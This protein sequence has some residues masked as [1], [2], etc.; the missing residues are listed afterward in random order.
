MVISRVK[1]LLNNFGIKAIFFVIPGLIDLPSHD[2][3]HS[4]N[5]YIFNGKIE[6]AYPLRL[7]TWNELNELKNDGHEIGCHGMTHKR[8][9]LLG[10]SELEEE[11]MASGDRLD[12]ALSQETNWYA[13]AF[14]DIYSI[15]ETAMELIS[16]R[17]R[18]SRSGI[19]GINT[20]K[21]SRYA[22]MAESITLGASDSY[23]ELILEGGLDPLYRKSSTQLANLA[24]NYS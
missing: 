4:I 2:Q 8:L 7:M 22:L 15:N 13:Y 18:Y 23:M 20:F 17:Y 21:T 9:S 10:P 5:K 11:V 16:K 1:K 3:F 14:G 6:P 12:N 24:Q 19:R